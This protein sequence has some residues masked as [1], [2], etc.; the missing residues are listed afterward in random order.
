MRGLSLVEL[1]L[2]MVLFGVLATGT[3]RI[4]RGS[5]RSFHQ[6]A[7]HSRIHA[8]L[9]TAV[10]LVA[11]ELRELGADGS[12]GDL[13]EIAPTAITY[14]A[15]RSTSF[16]CRRPDPSASEITV[17]RSPFYGLRELEAGRDSILIFAE[18]DPQTS[19][20]NA[21]HSA[22][23]VAVV[24]GDLCP[25][26]SAGMLIRLLGVSPGV[27]VGVER[28][29]PV[30][31]FQVTQLRLYQDSRRVYWL[32]W[33]EWRP[34]SGWSRTQ[35]VLG[36]LAPHGLKFG[37][38]DASGRATLNASRTAVVTM[39]VVAV[40]SGRAVAVAQANGV[41]TDSVTTTVALRNWASGSWSQVQ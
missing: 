10:A 14:R 27:L 19:D 29:A 15:M 13:I 9:R 11:S 5:M 39:K 22:A 37:Y 36:P 3:V 34:G 7:A 18:H 6:Q 21:W 23:V 1:L 31:G 26:R 28:G 41:M 16:L 35:P 2:A 20:D 32:G 4:A 12:S 33:K 38:L 40:S 24:R 8:S 17:W 25:G 30:R